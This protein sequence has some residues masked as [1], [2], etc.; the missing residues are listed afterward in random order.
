MNFELTTYSATKLVELM[1][2]REVSPVEVVTA[3]LR[4]IEQ[5]NPALNAV[6]TLAPDALEHARAA[7]ARMMR[8]EP[9]GALHG[10]PITIKDTIET[11]GLL[12]TSGSALRAETIPVEDAR[13]VARLRGAGAIVLG[14]TNTAEMAVPY[15]CDNPV[16]GQTNNPHDVTRTAGGSSGGEAA[17]IAACLS[18][19]G[20]GSDLAG[21]VRVP[22][23]FCGV[24][25]LKPTPGRVSL[26][27]HFPTAVGPLSLGASIGPM[28]RT[29]SDLAL[30]FSVIDEIQA[31]RREPLSSIG[32]TDL[33]GLR[34]A[35]YTDD[36]LSPVTEETRLAVEGAARALDDAGM[37]VAERRPPGLERSVELWPA[38]FAHTS[39]AETRALYEGCEDKAGPSVRAVLASG[40][41][42]E[43]QT[44]DEFVAAWMERDRLRETLVQW[45]TETPLLVAPV[46]SVAAFAHGSRKVSV[47]EQTI[48][49][50]RAFS[51]S[52]AFNV[53]GLPVVV[54]PAGFSS[55]GLPLGVQVIGRP[56]CE[57][58][59]LAAASVIEDARGGWQSPQIILSPDADNP[60]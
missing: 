22:A 2:A 52:R 60:L 18:T 25:G 31:S 28:A 59:A 57:E 54:V 40:A 12:T 9:V 19:C 29:V 38:L 20:L 53:L 42:G 56:F 1:R 14:K 32:R 15:E 49:V 55:E 48:S 41:K 11:R 6:V 23:H 39:Y 21:S 16:F 34:V 50:F 17:A 44:L 58:Q 51:Y 46:G 47:A 35:W 36:G 8:G 45:M 33:R 37:N 43:T 26:A 4:R 10:L 7:E 13:V 5:F 24:A 27:G 30:L 3:H